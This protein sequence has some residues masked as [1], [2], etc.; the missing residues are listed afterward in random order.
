MNTGKAYKD[1]DG[2][3]CTIY[4]MSKYEDKTSGNY[5]PEPED[6]CEDCELNGHEHLWV[7]TGQAV[8]FCA[9]CDAG[10]LFPQ[11]CGK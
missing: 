2:N 8:L 1:I 10:R 5:Q 7:P 3:D 6:Y 9:I 11:S 4:H